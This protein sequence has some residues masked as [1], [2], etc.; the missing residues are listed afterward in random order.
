LGRAVSWRPFSAAGCGV[1]ALTPVTLPQ[2]SILRNGGRFNKRWRSKRWLRFGQR[3]RMN[4]CPSRLIGASTAGSQGGRAGHA[5]RNAA[6]RDH[7]RITSGLDIAS[8]SPGIGFPSA[9]S[10]SH[11]THKS[12]DRGPDSAAST[13][14]FLSLGKCRLDSCGILPGPCTARFLHHAYLTPLTS[15]DIRFRNF[16]SWHCRN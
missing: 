9:H 6:I 8:P 15:P 14:S 2:R 5:N 16:H 10:K 12:K 11:P 13:P 1:R 4:A 3:V 7:R